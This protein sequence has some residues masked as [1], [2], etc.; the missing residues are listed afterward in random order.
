MFSGRYALQ[1]LLAQHTFVRVYNLERRNCAGDDPRLVRQGK[2]LLKPID[3]SFTH[4]HNCCRFGS[5]ESF[6]PRYTLVKSPF[7]QMWCDASLCALAILQRARCRAQLR[8]CAGCARALSARVV[9][10][11]G[12]KLRL[13]LC[14]AQETG[15]RVINEVYRSILA[16]QNSVALSKPKRRSKIFRLAGNLERTQRIFPQHESFRLEQHI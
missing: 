10:Q 1:L 15:A 4:T 13:S 16:R 7:K 8:A 2:R 11:H 9:V 12:P 5:N 6:S 3:E 14:A